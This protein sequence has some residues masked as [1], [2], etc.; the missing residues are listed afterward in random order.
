MKQTLGFL[1]TAASTT[2]R[3]HLY[4]HSVSGLSP[5]VLRNIGAVSWNLTGWEPRAFTS[6][7]AFTCHKY[8]ELVN[9]RNLQYG[10]VST[11]WIAVVLETGSTEGI[12]AF[13]SQKS[14]KLSLNSFN[15]TWEINTSDMYI[16]KATRWLALYW[17]KGSIPSIQVREYYPCK[18]GKNLFYVRLKL[19][20]HLICWIRLNFLLCM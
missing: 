14:S 6:R 5:A 4:L 19:V 9:I 7:G 1:Q 8:T 15:C 12:I 17:R 3:S 13:H 2:R 16:H 20:W 11:W 18:L 10:K